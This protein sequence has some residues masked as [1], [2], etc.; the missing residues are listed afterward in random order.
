MDTMTD[1]VDTGEIALNS[2][3]SLWVVDW[4]IYVPVNNCSVL[5]GEI[6]FGL[7]STK[8]GLMQNIR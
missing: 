3:P 2:A 1:R 4:F 8:Q 7:T 5:S 6:F